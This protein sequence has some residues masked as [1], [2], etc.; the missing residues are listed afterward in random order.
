MLSH[1]WRLVNSIATRVEHASFREI[2]KQTGFEN[3]TPIYTDDPLRQDTLESET[4]RGALNPNLVNQMSRRGFIDN[5]RRNRCAFLG[6]M[7]SKGV[8]RAK[9][10][11]ILSP[12]AEH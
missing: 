11:Y 10:N 2:V 6:T 3:I 4:P 5:F 1:W 12:V 8:R 9:L 7:S